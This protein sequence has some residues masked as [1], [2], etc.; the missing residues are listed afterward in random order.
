[1]LRNVQGYIGMARNIW[2]GFIRTPR[3]LS[4]YFGILKQ[5]SE[6]LGTPMETKEYIRIHR[7]AQKKTGFPRNT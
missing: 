5:T 6:N 3:N 4:E 2:E 7:D 1:M